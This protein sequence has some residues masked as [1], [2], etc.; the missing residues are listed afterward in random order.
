M[1]GHELGAIRKR[2]FRLDLANHVAH[3]F[4]HGVVLKNR[5][6]D[7]HDLGDR[8]A[9]ADELEEFS[10]DQRNG[11]RMIQLQPSGSP[12]SRELSGA[13]NDELIDLA[14]SQV[15][16]SSRICR[17]SAR[18]T[19]ALVSSGDLWGPADESSAARRAG[20]D[21]EK[22]STIHFIRHTQ[23]SFRRLGMLHL[24]SRRFTLANLGRGLASPGYTLLEGVAFA[25]LLGVTA[26]TLVSYRIRLTEMPRAAAS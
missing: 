7:A 6:P 26:I 15:H 8:S 24:V 2:A 11:L 4:H 20:Y 3:T 23:S 25:T 9:V 18:A 14:W 19:A 21:A 17:P 12:S 22:R 10:R 5:R 1:D 16:K 13:E